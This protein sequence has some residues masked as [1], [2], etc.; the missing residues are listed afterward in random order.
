MQ[1]MEAGPWLKGKKVGQMEKVA[2]TY[3]HCQLASG[4]LP[5]SPGS[6][7]WHSVMTE[8]GGMGVGRE[9]ERDRIYTYI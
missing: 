6:P 9:A 7:A 5:Y 1:K 4:E 2:L 8:R 3:I